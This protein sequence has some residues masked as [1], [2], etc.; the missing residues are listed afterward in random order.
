MRRS[1]WEERE[2]GRFARISC[3]R[4]AP[5]IV[6]GSGTSKGRSGIEAEKRT[7]MRSAST[8]GSLMLA[9]ERKAGDAIVSVR[10]NVES[11]TL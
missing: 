4:P 3:F 8:V 9:G 1:R 5:V 7:V 10:C 11:W 2:D 6:S